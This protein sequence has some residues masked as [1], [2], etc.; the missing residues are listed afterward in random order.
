MKFITGITS[1]YG[2]SL[3]SYFDSAESCPADVELVP[4]WCGKATQALR[5]LATRRAWVTSAV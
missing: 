1:K 2:F 4:L 5:S 3:S